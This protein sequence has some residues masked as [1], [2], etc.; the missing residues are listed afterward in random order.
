MTEKEK[1][2]LNLLMWARRKTNNPKLEDED[3]FA[4]VLDQ[5][6]DILARS[7]VV[8]ESVADLSQS[9]SGDTN[10]EAMGL[11]SPYRKAKFI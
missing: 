7:G 4:F 10:K 11:L 9:F 5:L 1:A 3:D 8:S 2:R 6:E